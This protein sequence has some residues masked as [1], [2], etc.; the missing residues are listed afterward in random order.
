MAGL[1]KE[2]PVPSRGRHWWVYILCVN[3]AFRAEDEASFRRSIHLISRSLH[4]GHA[5]T[6][7]T[8][9]LE[10]QRYETLLQR[11]AVLLSIVNV[12]Y[13]SCKFE[14][15]DCDSVLM[16][17]SSQMR[18]VHVGKYSAM[19]SGRGLCTFRPCVRRKAAEVQL[20]RASMQGRNHAPRHE[21]CG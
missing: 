7:H 12:S 17:Y 16:E 18:A 1:S 15:K 4:A 20:I 3:A 6:D 21:A 10:L 19:R 8:M 9:T 14:Q 2:G 11:Q 13:N 5:G